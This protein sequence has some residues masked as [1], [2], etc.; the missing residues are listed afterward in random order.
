MEQSW[1]LISIWFLYWYF[2]L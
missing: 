2:T 1:L